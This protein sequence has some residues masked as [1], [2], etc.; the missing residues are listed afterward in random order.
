MGANSCGGRG[1]F[2]KTFVTFYDFPDFFKETSSIF[3]K[4]KSPKSE[5]K[6]YFGGVAAMPIRC[7]PAL[8]ETF[9][10]LS[11]YLQGIP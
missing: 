5:E 1:T 3:A 9:L 8:S 4:I 2:P 11:N 6:T 7:P 10:R